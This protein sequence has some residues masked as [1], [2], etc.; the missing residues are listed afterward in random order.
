M[1]NVLHAAITNTQLP[2]TIKSA[3]EEEGACQ[4]GEVI[5]IKDLYLTGRADG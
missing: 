5:Q 4:R 3:H 2:V 1:T